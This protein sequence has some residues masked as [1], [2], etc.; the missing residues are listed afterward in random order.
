MKRIFPLF[1]FLSVMLLGFASAEISITQIFDSINQDSLVLFLVFAISFI[2]LLYALKKAFKEEKT[3]P[4]V[5]ALLISF[6]I[7][8]GVNQLD[9]GI[10]DWFYEI[11]ISQENLFVLLP[12]LVAVFTIFL[13]IKLKKKAFAI[14]GALIIASAFF[15]YEKELMITIGVILILIGISDFLKKKP[16]P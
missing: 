9:F 1:V 7:T 14:V 13:F 8:Y 4:V 2:I 16:T 11:G 10:G 15:V 3:I 12:L 6:G 5:L